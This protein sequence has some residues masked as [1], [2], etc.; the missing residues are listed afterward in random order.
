MKDEND[1]KSIP[2]L[3]T[4]AL[5]AGPMKD[6]PIEIKVFNNNVISIWFDPTKVNSHFGQTP[7][8]GTIVNKKDMGS[9][10]SMSHKGNMTMMAKG[11]SSSW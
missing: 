10:G 2:G 6:V 3:A 7:I 1:T 9:D 11:N 4:V 8:Y 5:R